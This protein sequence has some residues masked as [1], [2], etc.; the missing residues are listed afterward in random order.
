MRGSMQG[1]G[2]PGIGSA[3]WP[4]ERQPPIR[5]L[6]YMVV[7]ALGVTIQKSCGRFAFALVDAVQL[8]PS[9]TISEYV[10]LGR[11]A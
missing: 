9:Y 7:L 6:A 3:Y 1:H 10:R 11:G 2:R 8:A 4:H 5:G